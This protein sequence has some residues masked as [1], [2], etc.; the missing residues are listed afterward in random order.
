MSIPFR[1]HIALAHQY[2]EKIL[3]PGD[4]AIDA[5]CGNGRDTLKLAEVLKG[6]EVIGIDI[7]P[8]A[9]ANT[10][11]RLGSKVGVHLFCHSH[12]T[13]PLLAM[14]KPV[15]LI[16][17]NLGYLP[18]GNKNMTT[19]VESTLMSVRK[20][21]EIVLPYGAISITCYPGHAE[22]A[23]EEK[24]LLEELARWPTDRWDFCHHTFPHRRLAPSLLIIQKNLNRLI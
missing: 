16:V 1:P 24:A 23:L 3:Q 17:Y 13:F 8:E 2:W 20:A 21:S 14:Q 9:I 22:G 10:R 15:K 19:R 18:G 12:E 7:Q 6:G 11:E 5:T 4:W